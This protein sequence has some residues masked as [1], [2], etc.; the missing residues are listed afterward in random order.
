MNT[1]QRDIFWLILNDLVTMQINEGVPMKS[2]NPNST[3]IFTHLSLL[4]VAGYMIGLEILFFSFKLWLIMI[5]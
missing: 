2:L 5:F 1:E 4:N 3:T